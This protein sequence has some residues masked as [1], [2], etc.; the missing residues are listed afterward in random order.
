MRLFT[1]TIGPGGFP[2][3]AFEA[4]AECW[5]RAFEQHADLVLPC[6]RVEIVFV[7]EVA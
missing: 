4:F 5:A 6:E 1:I 7:R 2:R 3:L